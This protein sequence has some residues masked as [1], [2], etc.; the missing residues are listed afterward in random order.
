MPRDTSFTTS[1]TAIVAGAGFGG[2]AAALRMRA[3]GY[4]VHLIDRCV[5]LGGRGQVF[6]KDGF[7]H[8]AGPTVLTAPHLFE[9]LFALFGKQ[10]SDYVTLVEPDPWYRFQY[11]DGDTFDYGPTDAATEAEIARISPGDVVGYRRMAAWSKKIYDVGF[12]KLSDVP[13]HSV[14]FMLK[15]IPDLLRLRSYE[16]VWAMV[17]RHLRHDK[18]RRAFSIQ[19]L[20]LGGNPFSTT[21]I[22]GMINH[23]E[24]EHGV[25]FAMG[26]TGA[27]VDALE[28][29]ME[30]EGI[31]V[32]LATTI[33]RIKVEDGHATGVVL[34][35]GQDLDANVVV[36]NMDPVH[37]YRNMLPDAQITTLAKM[38]ST[39]STL[40]MGLYVLYFGATKTWPDVAHHTVWFGERYK[41]LL[42]DIFVNK[43][44][45]EDFSLYVHRPTATDPS[46]A[47][48][49]CD[50]FYV[51]CPVPNL[52]GQQDWT[53]EGPKLRDRIIAALEDTMLPGLSDHITAE[54]A[55]TPED[56][57]SDYLSVDGAGF[58]LSPF[59]TQ[60]AWFRFHNRGEGVRGLYFVGAGTHPGAGLPGVV[61]S[62]KVLE[63]LVPISEPVS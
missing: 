19:P 39:R 62:A 47:P 40:S 15:Q 14:G 28:R 57:R 27:L 49:G 31:K 34:E 35:N 11:A 48:D 37:V 5:R 44:L 1:Q 59:F 50:S 46:F 20:L 43:K 3:K 52:A 12:S 13:F 38:R 54:F 7:R 58:S 2:I 22:Y 26:G 21:A 25:W 36:S 9:E 29:L 23:L 18:L 41:D 24:R 42:Q 8:D 53:V 61:S 10:M 6:E 60:S 56:F 4:D 45:A 51:L 30:E 63:T 16:T 17:S 55:M 32:S 33:D